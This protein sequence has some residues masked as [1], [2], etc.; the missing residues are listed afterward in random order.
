MIGLVEMGGGVP[1]L[2]VKITLK[3]SKPPI[4]RQTHGHAD[5]ISIRRGVVQGELHFV[6]VVGGIDAVVQSPLVGETGALCVQAGGEDDAQEHC[7]GIFLSFHRRGSIGVHG[8]RR[9]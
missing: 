9:R 2:Q 4:W 5:A 6:E 3:E 1:L 8:L 7:Q